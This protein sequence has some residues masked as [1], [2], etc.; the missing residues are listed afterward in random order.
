MAKIAAALKLDVKDRLP[1]I[2]PANAD[3][4]TRDD[5]RLFCCLH[6]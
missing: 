4:A 3:T 6:L 1:S 2:L 5:C